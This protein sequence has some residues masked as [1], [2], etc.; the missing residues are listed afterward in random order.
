MIKRKTVKEKGKLSLSKYFQEFKVGDKVAIIRDQALNPGFPERIQGR[1]G[2]VIGTRGK[3]HLIKL[4]EG[5][6]VKVH[7]IRPLHLKK[8]K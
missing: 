6:A 5:N 3:A 2:T 7:I 4:N 1:T 8:L